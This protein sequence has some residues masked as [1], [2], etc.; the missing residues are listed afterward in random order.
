[1]MEFNPFLQQVAGYYVDA[2]RDNVQD[3][4]KLCFVFPNQRSGYFFSEYFQ[5]AFRAGRESVSLLQPRIT[6]LSSLVEEWCRTVEATQLELVMLL[7]R[8]YVDVVRP[9]IDAPSPALEPDRFLFWGDIILNDF[10]DID[11][12]LADP[13][14][15]FRNLK[16]FKELQTNPLDEELL[17]LIRQFWDTTSVPWIENT[18]GPMWVLKEENRKAHTEAMQNFIKLWEVLGILYAEFQKALKREGL[19]YVGMA[20][21]EAIARLER[22]VDDPGFIR[23]QNFVF[24]GFSS[25]SNAEKKIF[26]LLKKAGIARFHWDTNLPWLGEGEEFPLRLVRRYREMFPDP[27]DA[28]IE[29]STYSP[30]IKVYSVPSEIGQVKQ[31]A[32]MLMNDPNLSASSALEYALVLPENSLCMPMLNSLKMP[33]G[34]D[35]NITMGYPL[36]STPMA[37]VMQAVTAL[38]TMTENEGDKR[39]FNRNTVTDLVSLPLLFHCAPEECKAVLEEM[40][41]VRGL[42][43]SAAR[44]MEK[45]GRLGFLFNIEDSEDVLTV[46]ERMKTIAVNLREL[47]PR[48][49]FK[50]ILNNGNGEKEE[51]ALRGLDSEFLD[52]YIEQLNDFRHLVEKYSLEEY[53]S[54]TGQRVFTTVDNM[55]RRISLSFVGAPLKGIQMMGILETRA[56]DFDTVIITSMNE[57]SFPRKLQKATFIPQ[58]LRRGYGLENRNDEEI[59]MAYHFYRLIG[60]A[61]NVVLLYNNDTEGLKSGEMSRYIYQLKYLYRYPFLMETTLKYPAWAPQ[62]PKIVVGKSDEMM[63]RLN[64]YLTSYKGDDKKHMSASSIKKLLG[65][66]LQFLLGAV[67]DFSDPEDDYSHI[68]DSM[69]GLIVHY[70]MEHVYKRYRNGEPH[71]SINA[72]DLNSIIADKK[73]LPELAKEAVYSQ[74]LNEKD[75]SKASEALKGEQ[76]IFSEMAIRSVRELLKA[77]KRYLEKNDLSHFVVIGTEHKET[78]D[79]EI[80]PEIVLNFKYIIDRVDRMYRNDGSSYL[81]IVDYKTGSDSLNFESVEKL[82]DYES[83]NDNYYPPTAITQLM[84]YSIAYALDSRNDVKPGEQIQPIIYKFR[85]ILKGDDIKPLKTRNEENKFIAVESYNDRRMDE[86]FFGLLRERLVRLFNPKEPFTQSESLHACKY[87]DFKDICQRSKNKV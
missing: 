12:A 20:Y 87:C 3:L 77:E 81:R 65:C 73:L 71:P 47:Y 53:I 4:S 32:G 49:E 51:T 28:I 22:L 9:R 72:E 6:T 76:R 42:Y 66:E 61:H 69:Y 39:V 82:V 54:R 13:A 10:N 62:A 17:D 83:P 2:Y 37:A 26:K 38:I 84:L 21:R 80:T 56:L 29:P 70:M 55:V 68:D 33:P 74:Y 58:S 43:V 78:I 64:R 46:L 30:L 14:H 75:K 67:S 25:L 60:R 5:R 36:K 7:F 1:M 19:C 45:A 52:V 79:L 34:V 15:L 85:D 40:S 57:R 86:K 24:V 44:L 35:V 18:D 8:T 48:V 50:K 59:V 16:D 23:A 63:L 11:K 41:R 31:V 27:E